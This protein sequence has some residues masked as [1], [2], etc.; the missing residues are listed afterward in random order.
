MPAVLTLLSGVAT[1]SDEA[2]YQAAL[3]EHLKAKGH[4]GATMTELGQAVRYHT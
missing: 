3:V 1:P 4:A 2:G